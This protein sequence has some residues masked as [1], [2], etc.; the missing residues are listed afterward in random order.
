MSQQLLDQTGQE[1]LDYALAKINA[2]F[3]ELYGGTGGAANPSVTTVTASGLI[4]GGTVTSTGLATAGSVKLDTGTKTATA[5]AGAAT[6]NKS[7]GI[8]TTEALT[9]AAG[10]DYTLTLTNS[11]IAAGDLALVSVDSNSSAGLPLAYSAKT[12]ANTLT[13]I[14]RNIHATAAFNAALKIGFAIFKA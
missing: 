2:N 7:S 11:T 5:S 6:L 8:I 13:V 10:S 4:Q 14:V 12:T 3:T 9:T 1:R